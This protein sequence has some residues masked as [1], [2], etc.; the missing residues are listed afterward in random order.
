[1]I[2]KMKFL[3]ITGPKADIDRVVETY[4]S[5]YEIHLEH[6]I[7]QLQTVKN[8][9]PYLQINPYREH[10]NKLSELIALLEKNGGLPDTEPLP[11]MTAEELTALAEQLSK[12]IDQMSEQREALRA[13]RK[14]LVDDRNALYPFRSLQL[15]LGEM[16]KYQFIK[17]RFGRIAREY[18]PNFKELI[19]NNADS[20]FFPCLQDDHYVW[21]VYFCPRTMEAKTEA[22]YTSL[23]FEQVS[24]PEHL[25][26]TPEDAYRSLEQQTRSMREETQAMKEQII[27]ILKDH[28]S[29]LVAARKT[30]EEASQVFDVRKLAACTKEEHE[31]FYIL[32]GWMSCRDAEKLQK[33]I[34]NDP[35]VF[36]FINDDS[37]ALSKPPTKLKNPRIFRPFEMFVRM[38]GLPA[39]NEIDPTLFVALT[40]AF[41]FG[42]M[43][44]D[45][46]QGVLLCIGGFLLYK[47]KKMDLAAIIGTAGIF[48][49]I[50]GLLFG[51]V[52][53][54]EDIL[55]ALWLRPVEAMSRLPFVGSLNTVFVVAIVFG[56]FLIMVTMVFHICNA[57]KAHQTEGI[58]FDQNAVAG[59]VFYAAVVVCIFLFMTGHS[60]PAGI[61]LAVMFGV[62]LLV[63]FFKEPLTALVEK[64]AKIM[65]EQKG[66][67]FVQGFF[68]MFEVL[69][70]YFSN[71]LSF[72]RIG[73][74]AVSHGAMMEVV[75]M[76]AGAESGSPNWAVIVF[77]NLFVM[78][79]E[80][81]IV[82]IQVL[83]L[84][85]YEMFSR[86]YSGT[87][88]EFHPFMKK[89]KQ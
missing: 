53:G 27:R 50:F 5:K 86:F 60:L 6:T 56:M 57:V 32:C 51:S 24:M 88:R 26:G 78:L 42:V 61:V 22:M 85:Y 23:H 37:E 67:F 3:S 49:T 40:Y 8:L 35:Q 1:M 4:L 18:F 54:F 64:H 20:Y 82:G 29:E 83:R 69:L 16:E 70:S 41:I 19:Y 58:W 30:L 10:L 33:D 15:D 74:Y 55:P 66:M 76:L 12:Q 79:L 9:T 62:P 84:E 17:Y 44:G 39:Y 25:T 68:E 28:A 31:T 21:G 77:G 81:L 87:G 36:C 47:F 46:G 52:F 43:F 89:A 11:H 2:E 38:Y 34:E 14:A 13:K 59:L 71:T 65:P 80:G 48:S 7:E 73:A 75:L 63:I 72:V 45:A